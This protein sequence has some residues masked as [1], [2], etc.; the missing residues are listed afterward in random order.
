MG[1]LERFKEGRGYTDGK[2]KELPFPGK[3]NYVRLALLE[4]PDQI[5]P[6]GFTWPS[7]PFESLKEIAKRSGKKKIRDGLKDTPGARAHLADQSEELDMNLDAA[8]NLGETSPNPQVYSGRP[9]QEDPPPQVPHAD[10]R[11]D[12]NENLAHNTGATANAASLGDETKEDKE[13]H[14]EDR[15][16]KSNNGEGK[17]QKER[18][19]KSN[20][21]IFNNLFG[22]RD[23]KWTRFFNCHVEG[24]MGSI[25]FRTE[26]KRILGSNFTFHRR[27]DR[28]FPCG[29][30][31][32]RKCTEV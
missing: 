7:K 20:V 14:Q 16:K 3:S 13:R 26:T 32:R 21:N 19:Y 4:N 5:W 17:K 30:E 28:K 12:V 9:Q 6:K 22:R 24:R 10:G 1:G 15:D 25:K 29:C 27:Q 11:G 18:I 2:G 23:E 31:N 8:E